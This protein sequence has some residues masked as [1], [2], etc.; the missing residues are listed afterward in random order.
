MPEVDLTPLADGAASGFVNR[1]T[2]LLGAAGALGAVGLSRPARA[3]EYPMSVAASSSPRFDP[4]LAR[5]L[6][7]VLRRARQDPST[8]FPGAILH[9]DSPRLGTWT[10][11]AGVAR[12]AP[13]EP[14]RPDDRFRAGSIVKTFVSVVVLQLAER[15][16]L[17]LDARLPEAL[18]ASVVDRFPT[19]A[20]VSVRMLLSHRSGIPDWD[21]PAVEN[22]IA[23]HP[24]KV[25]KL[26]EF[27]DLA[28]AQPPAFAPGT[29]YK[30]SNTDYN[31][32]GL[33]VEQVTGRSWRHE[34]A[35]RVISPLGLARTA[36]PAPGHRSLM[37]A[38]AH[39][40]GQL[41]GA[42]VD[43]TRIDPSM[44]GAAGGGALVTTVQDLARFLNALLK[45]RLFRRPQTLRQML[46]FAPAPDVGGQIGYG[47]GIEWRLFPGGV[48]AIGHLGSTAGYCA[49]VARL[50]PQGVTIASAL[51]WADDPT[52]LLL[53][54]VKALAAA[55]R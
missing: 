7:R 1:R 18:P 44:A 8:H 27:L 23:H 38:H 22:E 26:S 6:Q 34:V 31:L 42:R 50:R 35:R 54:A 4:A 47:L 16:R 36:L 32:L 12:V 33:I 21:A 3:A 15:G 43:L 45:R 46:A 37:G 53:P 14:M 40:Y 5:R 30:Y 55:H 52:P 13:A 49:Y 19:A 41:D 48:S 28:A 11:V 2:L 24:A 29:D 10:G 17:S 51:N 25:W 39:G 20:G 9:V